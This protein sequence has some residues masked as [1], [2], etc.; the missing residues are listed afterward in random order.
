MVRVFETPAPI[1]DLMATED[2]VLYLFP[3]NSDLC[4]SSIF[5]ESF[6]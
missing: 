6:F 5:V 2:Q 1:V 4:A 3:F